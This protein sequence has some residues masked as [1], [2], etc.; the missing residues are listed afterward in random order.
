MKKTIV[1]LTLIFV[2]LAGIYAM[3]M[4][5]ST[6]PADDRTVM[7]KLW[8][9]YDSARGADRPQKQLEILGDIKK[10][11]FSERLPWDYYQACAKY[12]STGIARNWKLADSLNS[13]FRR[14][15]KDF[16]EPILTFF[17]DNM[18]FKADPEFISKHR[19]VLESARNEGFYTASGDLQKGG[20]L[21]VSI[22]DYIR[23]DYQYAL[24]MTLAN[25]RL[26]DPDAGKCLDMLKASVSGSYPAE[27]L[28]Q[29]MQIL[30]SDDRFRK[31]EELEKFADGHKSRAVSLAA[32]QEL[33]RLSF[34]KLNSDKTATSTQFRELREKC[35]A[36]EKTR[37]G[38]SGKEKVIADQCTGVVDLLEVMD[39]KNIF[40]DI[41]DGVLKVQ[42]KNVD[43]VDVSI[44]DKSTV[45]ASTTLTNN[46]RSYYVK[47]TLTYTLPP[48]DDGQYDVVF[49][50][51][52]NEEK[53]S[54]SR[55]SIAIAQRHDAGGY[56]IFLADA[57]TG[58]PLKSADIELL[59]EDG[60]T[61]TELKNLKLDGFTYLP[62]GFTSHFHAMDSWKDHLRCSFKGKDG[63][64]HRTETMRLHTTN[65]SRLVP[66]DLTYVEIFTDRASFNP[67]E[68]VHF[69]IVAFHGFRN[70]SLKVVGKG[71]TLTAKLFDAENK[72]ISSKKLTTNEFG[73]AAG[74][75][76]LERRSR[77]GYYRIGIFDGKNQ[78]G[79]TSIRV[80]D[81]I[82]PTFELTF[83]P[84]D[85]IYFPGDEVTV[86]GDIK[87]FSG[88]SLSAADVRYSVKEN[89]RIIKEGRLDIGIDG[90]FN[91]PFTAEGRSEYQYYNIEVT[92]TD[93]TG[94]TLS[95]NTGIN[96][97]KQIPFSAELLNRT[98]ASLSIIGRHEYRSNEFYNQEVVSDD[99][100][101]IK[102]HTGYE[103]LEP[104]RPTLK[105]SYRLTLG[106]KMIAEGTSAPGQ[107]LELSTAGLPSG[108]YT[109]EAEAVDTDAYGNSIKSLVCYDI[110]KVKDNDTSLAFDAANLF[111]IIEG[112]DIAVQIGSTTGPVWAC[113]EIFGD[114]DRLLESRMVHL[115][116][117][118]GVKGSLTTVR[119]GW[120][121]G[122]DAVFLHIIYFKNYTEY[123]YSH[124]FNRIS[125]KLDLP[126]S[127]TRFEDKTVPHTPY[128]FE[129]STAAGVECVAAIFD[130]GTESVMP[131]QWSKVMLWGPEVTYIPYS[132][133]AG[134]N[135]S[136]GFYYAFDD[137]VMDGGVK[138]T[139]AAGRVLAK[140][141][142]AP[143]P[144]PMAVNS[145][146]ETAEMEEEASYGS[147]PVTIRENFANTI[148][149]EPFLRSDASGKITLDFTT[150]DK[151]STYYVQLFAHDADMNNSVLR[152]E[153]MVTIPVKVS[154]MEPQFLF[155][156][157]RY[158][159]K[160]ALSSSVDETV[161]GYLK[162]DFFDGKDYKSSE[163]LKSMSR[164][165]ELGAL[166]S[167]SEEFAIDVPAVK[168]L[169]ILL[170]FVAE[171]QSSG[172][173]AVF[174]SVPVSAA[175]QTLTEAHSAI[176]HNGGSL[177]AILAELKPMFVN[178]S[179]EDAEMKDISVLQMVREAIPSKAEAGSDDVIALSGALYV[180]LLAARLG[181]DVTVTASNEEILKKILGCRR[182]DGGFSWFEGMDSSPVVTATL[183]QRYAS[184]R[185]RGII[186]PQT[187]AIPVQ[188]VIDAVKFLDRSY[189]GDGSRP[190][191]CGGLS[192]E[193]YISI[194]AMFPEVP[195]SD[196]GIDGKVI[197]DFRKDMKEYLTPRKERGLEGYI[198]GKARRM[199]VLLD[200][201]ACDDGRALA[202][203]WGVTLGTRNKILKSLHKDLQ[204]IEE[205]A[206][207]HRSGGWYY[208]NAVMPFRGLLESEAYAHAFIAD[209][210]KDC[211]PVL[212][213]I[214]SA[215]EL[216]RASEIADGIRLWLMVQKETQKWDEDAAFVDA[217]STILDASDDVLN[218]RVITLS[219]TYTKPLEDIKASG[220]G[221]TVERRFFI[222]KSGVKTALADGDTLRTGDK[223][224]AEY[225][226]WNEENR[227]F[228]KVTAPRMASMRPVNQLS[229]NYRWWL[230]PLSVAGW[231]SFS[232][233]GYR[234]VLDDRTEYWFDTYPEETTVITEEFFVTQAGE[235]R[236][237]V[238][239]VESLYAPHYR[240]NDNGHGP[241]A[242]K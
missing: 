25:T 21:P 1:L 86:S 106:D 185:K 156:G 143:A 107:T 50:Y 99:V 159:V 142:A 146:V 121:A 141:A 176:L 101:K 7:E 102:L 242:S 188:T 228:V 119:F 58:E 90:H 196:K 56:A 30:K 148:I 2:S 199:K 189:F 12:R 8:K 80:D 72:E 238:M 118:K 40:Y 48:F 179:A 177:E 124:S 172:S 137:A 95:W 206:I 85:R 24:W 120:P 129:I 138:S 35:T 155:A 60:K 69:K 47:D 240:A 96:V 88:H 20:I 27:D 117:R 170:T 212:G 81:F 65:Y 64:I 178:A 232:P 134:S 73:S 61:I 229:G 15:M 51:E 116:G 217:L 115:D 160:A 4:K 175:E 76:L 92:A 31:M 44:K 136:N 201:S 153:M 26:S 103:L 174:V 233:H 111:R 91:I 68:T 23:N 225:H 204:S 231:M 132:T 161:S 57:L 150:A 109:F 236:S 53:M 84:V 167:L 213:G 140:A 13:Q 133:N 211:I 222:E 224:I 194:R 139:R 154:V 223:V 241:I 93:A 16:D 45:V 33:L 162:A 152:Q 208:P 181:S 113:V 54:F 125:K 190:S 227:S 135:G 207:E 42:T 186:D 200:L 105:I 66:E 168:E 163:P 235:F 166:E 214:A 183:L 89:S 78:I 36:F 75:F 191:W 127:F 79:G 74:E 210:M 128:S 209:L 123:T 17:S 202:Q 226:I 215:E 41:K 62:S 234:S 182:S 97:Q 203:S 145:M 29:L 149:F 195:F 110:Y 87:S 55:F 197:K 5:T 52:G 219:K 34:E 114:G 108:Q 216:A 131:N 230:R 173:D 9:D 144:S 184:L 237:A 130:K 37:K 239:E 147:S 19:S 14:E 104:G 221:F 18:F 171:G 169:G 122:Q 39:S 158:Q 28:L 59:N 83:D 63:L 218:I 11:A 46:V 32:T 193:Q 187:C 3:N 220:N 77:N 151:L 157:D 38:F 100:F 70:E 164:K 198:L 180:R 71:S 22:V 126:L 165:V 82:L 94:E 6:T 67:D 43:R 205:Y 98:E 192:R 49:K 112:E 10:L